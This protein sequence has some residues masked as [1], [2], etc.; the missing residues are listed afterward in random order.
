MI[1]RVTRNMPKSYG[2]AFRDIVSWR[3][4]TTGDVHNGHHCASPVQGVHQVQNGVH[5]PE[6]AVYKLQIGV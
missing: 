4:H 6:I 2:P 1:P 5:K 3:F